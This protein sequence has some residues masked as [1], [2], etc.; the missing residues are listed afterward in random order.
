VAGTKRINFSQACAPKMEKS[1]EKSLCVLIFVLFLV[2]GGAEG[3]FLGGLPKKVYAF[4]SWQSLCVWVPLGVDQLSAFWAWSSLCILGPAQRGPEI[5]CQ[6]VGS[7]FGSNR[8]RA[9]PP[10]ASRL[11]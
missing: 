5:L 6:L 10:V 4:G 3:I 11:R 9:P 8:K 1:S 7:R 2:L